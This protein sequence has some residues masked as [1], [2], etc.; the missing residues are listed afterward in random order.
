VCAILEEE[1]GNMSHF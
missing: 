1:E